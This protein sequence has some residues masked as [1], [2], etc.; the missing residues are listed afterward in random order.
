MRKGHCSAANI[1]FISL[2]IQLGATIDNI[3][4]Y[5]SATH[6]DF[7]A[8]FFDNTLYVCCSGYVEEAVT[9]GQNQNESRESSQQLSGN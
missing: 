5:Q 3:L 6:P 9:A 7:A 4:K 1:D 8:N 2:A